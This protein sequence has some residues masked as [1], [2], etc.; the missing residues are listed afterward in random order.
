M[1]KTPPSIFNDVI[2][3]VMRGPSSSH[4]AASVRIGRMVRQI[5]VEKPLQVLFEFDPHGSLA[6]T[7]E[8]QGSAM[9]LAAGLLNWEITHPNLQD[10]LTVAKEEG[11]NLE[12]EIVPF[13]A[14]HPNTYKISA[15][16]ISGKIMTFIVVSLGGGMIEFSKI[17]G[18]DISLEGDFYESLFF[19][20]HLSDVD[21][22][23]IQNEIIRHFP[24][25]SWR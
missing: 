15:E 12:F 8:S 19:F 20:K 24:S 4:T 22:G 23:N 1:K 17:N 6:T 3:P 2:G 21:E 9:G 10:S 14:S 13:P 11:L 18:M 5:L 16:G 25:P 7:Y